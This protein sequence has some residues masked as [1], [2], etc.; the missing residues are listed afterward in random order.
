MFRTLW[1]S[2]PRDDGIRSRC[3]NARPTGEANRPHD[4]YCAI[5]LSEAFIRAGIRLDGFNG[6]RCWS[7][8]CSGTH[9][10]RAE[11]LANWLA[12]SA[13]S[14]F[15]RREVVR[16]GSFQQDLDGRTGVIFFGDYWQRRRETFPNRTGDHIDLWNRTR[17]TGRPMLMRELAELFGF[18]SDLNQS[19]TVWFWE[20]K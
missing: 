13:P 5:R 7:P 19:K 9:A 18:V 16:P 10:I 12:G 20:V 17:L 3:Y 4:N 2:F 11:E 14:G 1:D 15:G 8:N 6:V